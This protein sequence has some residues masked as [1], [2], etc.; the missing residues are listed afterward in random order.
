MKLKK[1]LI[2]IT[3]KQR[4]LVNKNKELLSRGKMPEY[5][6]NCNILKGMDFVMVELKKVEF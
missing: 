6:N 4:N 3:D 2:I 5:Q 1:F